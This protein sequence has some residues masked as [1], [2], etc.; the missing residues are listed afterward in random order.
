[1]SVEMQELSPECQ[2]PR[3]FHT[4]A[5]HRKGLNHNLAYLILAISIV[6]QV[7]D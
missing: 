6:S 2:L 5:S 7:Q 4:L 3:D 1:M